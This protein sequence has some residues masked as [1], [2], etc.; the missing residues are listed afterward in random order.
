MK[1]LVKII[2]TTNRDKQRE[3]C[4]RCAIKLFNKTTG[5]KYDNNVNQIF[6]NP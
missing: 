4:I 2:K 5:D 3:K 6:M 1:N